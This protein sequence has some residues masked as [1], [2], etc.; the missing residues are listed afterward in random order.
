MMNKPTLAELMD[1]GGIDNKY[2]LVIAIA[3]RARRIASGEKPL[4]DVETVKP[5]SIAAIE[6][7]D[8]KIHYYRRSEQTT[9]EAVG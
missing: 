4:V 1:Q 7:A 9:N 5:V 2:A 6:L 3:K 8:G